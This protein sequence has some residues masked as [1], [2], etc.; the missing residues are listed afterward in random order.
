M[1]EI[2]TYLIKNAFRNY[3]VTLLTRN[4]AIGLI[5]LLQKSDVPL[6]GVEGFVVRPEI[7]NV[8]IDQAHGWVHPYEPNAV[9]MTNHDTWEKG[10]Q[11]LNGEPE[12]GV[13]YELGFP[14]DLKTW[15][16]ARLK[17]RDLRVYWDKA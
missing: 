10:K 1:D 11:F 17:M 9:Q 8:Q 6:Y 13:L 3:G 2:F 5:D 16:E 14:R 15:N 12:D 4:D 7:T